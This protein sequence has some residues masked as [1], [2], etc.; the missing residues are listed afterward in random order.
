MS[1]IISLFQNLLLDVE[2]RWFSPAIMSTPSVSGVGRV[3]S[4]PHFRE[5]DS[6]S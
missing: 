5:I 3:P 1:V 2:S 6:R 4:I